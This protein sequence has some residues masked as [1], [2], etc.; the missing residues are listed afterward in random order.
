M[1]CK[2]LSTLFSTWWLLGEALVLLITTIMIITA[3]IIL[4]KVKDIHPS[5]K[6][7]MWLLLLLQT[8]LYIHL[9]SGS[10]ALSKCWYT[11]QWAFLQSCLYQNLYWESCPVILTLVLV[12]G[13]REK[14]ETGITISE[15]IR[16]EVYTCSNAWLTLVCNQDKIMSGNWVVVVEAG[17]GCVYCVRN[18]YWVRSLLA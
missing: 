18:M 10:H 11:T 15:F 16:V 14:V 3:L 8:S 4:T 9:H 5:T 2:A 1:Q 6:Q 13:Y 17:W 12:Q 7:R